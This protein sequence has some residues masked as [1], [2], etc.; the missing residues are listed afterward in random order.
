MHT[1]CSGYDVAHPADYVAI[2]C[3]IT[4]PAWSNLTWLLMT[5][6]QRVIVDEKILLTSF[7][8][9]VLSD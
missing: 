7:Q 3:R 6:G 1:E 9:L 8:N 4:D 2:R 5:T